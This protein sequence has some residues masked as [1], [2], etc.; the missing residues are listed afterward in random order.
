LDPMLQS[1][2]LDSIAHRHTLDKLSE[3][4]LGLP[5]ATRDELLGKGRNKLGFTQLSVPDAAAWSAKCAD[6]THRLAVVLET[7]LKQ[8]GS[9]AEVYR[10]FEIA[11]V[12]VLTR[13]E[14]A[15]IRVNVDV[16]RQQSEE[17]A[18][19]L[20]VLEKRAYDLAGEE[21]NLGSPSQL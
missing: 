15:G 8:T 2:V 20:D 9:L 4:E 3:R 1:Y 17:L 13:M 14:A 21:F 12:P 18:V 5:L 7:R 10:Y 16:L 19:R 6:Y 11:L